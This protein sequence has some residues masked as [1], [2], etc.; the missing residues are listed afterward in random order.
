MNVRPTTSSHPA[1]ETRAAPGWLEP[2]RVARW[3]GLTDPTADDD[4]L[5]AEVCAQ[6]VE[7]V[8]R[9]RSDR[10]RLDTTTPGQ[11]TER[12]FDPDPETLQGAVMFAARAFRRRS[13]PT[14]VQSFG[15]AGVSYVARWDADIDRALRVGA[16]TPPAVG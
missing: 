8:Q 11:P 9:V 15:D 4:L 1:G 12:V 2:A 6:T 3:L 16:F 13:S 5:L 14:G 10:Y 7:H